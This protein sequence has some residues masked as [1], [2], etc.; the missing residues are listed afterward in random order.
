MGDGSRAAIDSVMADI[1]ARF[2]TQNELRMVEIDRFYA[3]QTEKARENG[4]TQAE[5]DTISL[6]HKRDIELEKHHAALETLDF[7][8]QI[9]IRRAQI[10]DKD[11]MLQ[12]Q[13]QEKLLKI[14]IA[15]AE[16]RKDSPS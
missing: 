10:E 13:R 9:A 15:A 11:V 5:L 16:K 12:S 3:E 2:K 1:D 4:A 8:A 14:Q 6:Q 7:E